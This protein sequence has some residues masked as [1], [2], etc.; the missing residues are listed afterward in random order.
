MWLSGFAVAAA[1]ALS[2]SLQT[3][4][5]MTGHGHAFVRILA[6]ELTCWWFWAA[7]APLLTAQGARIADPR[8]LRTR[9]WQRTAALVL[10]LMALHVLVD[11][12]AIVLVQPFVP[13][14]SYGFAA[15]LA[16]AAKSEWMFDIIVATLALWL[17]GGMMF[18]RYLAEFPSVYVS[19]YAGLASVMIALVFLYL[20]ASIF[21]FGGE[22]NAAILRARSGLAANRSPTVAQ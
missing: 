9:E 1:A 16:T 14:Q 20:T 21:V 19:Y 3:Y 22:L 6:W 13:V 5:S 2:A 11:A 10:A 8:R 15:A 12:V 18:G 4:V 17:A 7:V